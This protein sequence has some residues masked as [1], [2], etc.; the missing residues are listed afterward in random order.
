MVRWESVRVVTGIAAHKNWLIHQTDVQTA[1]LYGFLEGF[2]V[3]IEQSEGFVCPCQES[4][5]CKLHRAL[6]G[7]KQSPRAWYLR[8]GTFL[9]THSLSMSSAGPT[10]TFNTCNHQCVIILILY[11]DDLMITSSCLSLI[12][13]LQALLHSEFRM[14]D[15][16]DIQKFLGVD[17]T[18]T[19]ENIFLHQSQYAKQILADFCME[20]AH[21][22]YVPMTEGLQ[23]RK[24]TQTP[25]CD[26][27]LYRALVGQLQW[28]ITKTCFDVAR[29]VGKITSN[30]VFP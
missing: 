21:P 29:V 15:L 6:Y 2:E 19:P 28:L 23:L 18:R 30:H 20:D 24:D 1:F 22:T 3:S 4:K 26:P 13:D 7:L 12:R 25:P 9:R 14:M 17:F 8:V 5:V 10:Y 16:G 27:F 11:V